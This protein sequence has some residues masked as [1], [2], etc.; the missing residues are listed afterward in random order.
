MSVR[1]EPRNIDNVVG[2]ILVVAVVVSS[3]HSCCCSC[4]SR[5][6]LRLCVDFPH[7]EMIL[8]FLEL[9]SEFEWGFHH[10]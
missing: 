9:S 5:G 1:R 8:L 7:S 2:S 6:H 4:H 10:A 3:F